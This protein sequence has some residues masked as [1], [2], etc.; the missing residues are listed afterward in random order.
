M[1]QRKSGIVWIA[2]YPRSGNT[3]V[4]L[5]ICNLAALLAGKREEENFNNFLRASPWDAE[6]KHYQKYIKLNPAG[7]EL[8]IRDMLSV[9]DLV[10]RDFAGTKKDMVFAKTHWLLEEAFGHN[11]FDFS[12]TAGAIYCVRNPLDVSISLAHHMVIP[13]DHAIEHMGTTFAITGD[14][15]IDLL[16]SWSRN[17]HSWTKSPGPD[18]YV[19]RYEDLV[20]DPE[21]WFGAVAHHIF[22]PAPS[23]EQIK[24]AIHRSSFGRLKAQEEAHG[25]FEYTDKARRF[26]REGRFG[27]WKKVLTA[28][29]IHR[30]I[31]DHG[32]VMARFG[33]WPCK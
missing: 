28:P 16:G 31:R 13:V 27:Q 26:F 18:I 19:V 12:V 32:V 30:I 33:Y 9:R 23:K 1:L 3:W 15:I 25:Y 24:E 4:R 21:I 20:E 22:D 5:F 29:Q 11:T 10:L 8:A 17:V 6:V 14:T 2:A 7:G